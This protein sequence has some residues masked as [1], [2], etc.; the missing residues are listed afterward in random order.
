[1]F[2]ENVKIKT[3][4]INI[5]TYCMM[6][7]EVHYDEGDLEPFFQGL[8]IFKGRNKFESR[9]NYHIVNKDFEDIFY[10][11]PRAEKDTS[12]SIKRDRNM[13]FIVTAMEKY[14]YRTFP[15]K[16]RDTEWD[17]RP[18]ILA[19]LTPKGEVL[20]KANCLEYIKINKIVAR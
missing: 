8:A 16:D 17:L 9:Y 20:S 14:N 12:I 13:Y 10:K 11:V 18:I 15:G 2:M 19:I 6:D 3:K 5:R 4:I 7:Y 1:M